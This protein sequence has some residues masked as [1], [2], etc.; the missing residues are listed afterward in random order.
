M[1]KI[2]D[3]LASP[4]AIWVKMLQM[5][6]GAIA[7]LPKY[8]DSLPDAFK[9]SIPPSYLLYVSMAGGFIIFLLQLTQKP[10]K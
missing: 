1:K 3:R 5:L 7:A 2:I 9:S 8:Y 10:Q 4:T 6:S